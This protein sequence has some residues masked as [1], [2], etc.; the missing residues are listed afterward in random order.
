MAAV[1]QPNAAGSF[2]AS[3]GAMTVEQLQKLI[4]AAVS[5][6]AASGKAEGRPQTAESIG[7]SAQSLAGHVLEGLRTTERGINEPDHSWKRR[8]L[9]VDDRPENNVYERSAF[10]SLGLEF[11]LALSTKQALDT[12]SKNQFA[13][14]ISDMGR[15]EGP[16]EGY[17]LL[18]AVRATNSNTPFFIYAGS[19]APA[20]KREAIARGAQGTTNRVQ[21]LFDMVIQALPSV[22]KGHDLRAQPPPASRT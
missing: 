14:I 21:E 17:V 5:L 6:A 20:H 2:P 4:V 10:E 13:A 18:E 7:E 16:R 8:I 22:D 1:T 3:V 12:L 9:W 19:N 15:K 11:T